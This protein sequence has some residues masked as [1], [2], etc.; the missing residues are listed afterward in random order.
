MLLHLS[1]ETGP[2]PKKLRAS[3][4][5]KE[6]KARLLPVCS[7]QP[8]PTPKV[9]KTPSKARELKVRSLHNIEPLEVERASP[10]CQTM[11]GPEPQA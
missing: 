10:W 8:K 6:S 11:V 2:T 4:T 3:F 5:R 1:D 9:T 7:K